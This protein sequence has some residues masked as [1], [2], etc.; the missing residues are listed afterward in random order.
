MWLSSSASKRSANSKSSSRHRPRSS[1]STTDS[2]P[3]SPTSAL[4]EVLRK[5]PFRAGSK[6]SL[7]SAR[8]EEDPS[9]ALNNDLHILADFYPDV[10]VE[11]VREL[12]LQFDG[13]SRLSICTEQLYKYKTEWAKG[14]MNVPPRGLNETIPKEE[15]FRPKEYIEAVKWTASRE[16]SVLGRST[17]DAVLAEVN[18]SYTSAR[19]T[20]Q[21]LVSRSW[22]AAFS[23]LLK[24]RRSPSEAPQVLLDKTKADPGG[25]RLV[26]TGSHELDRELSELFRTTLSPPRKTR[27]QKVTDLEYA[28]ALNLRQAEEIGALYECQ[29]CYNDTTF[30]DA[31]VCSHS[32]HVICLDCVRRALDEALFGQGWAKSVDVEHGTLKCIAPDDCDGHIPQHLVER[33]LICRDPASATETWHRFEERLAE[34]NLQRSGLPLVRCQFCP[35]AEAEQVYDPD[36]AAHIQWR[37]R[38]P[39]TVMHTIIIIL[40]LELL[41]AAVLFLMPFLLLFPTYFT[42]LFYTSLS[43]L[44]LKLRTSRFSCQNPSCLRKSCLKCQKAW[45]DPHICHEP[46]I[47]SLRTSVEAARTA[48]IKRICPRC[49]TSFVKSSGCNKLTCVC[50]YS[51]CY[52]CRKNIGKAGDN[53]EGGE[54]YRHF[55]EH[56]RPMPG[57]G[58]TECDKCDLYRAEDEDLMVKKAGEEAERLWREREG[59]VGVKGLE[60]AVGNVAGEDTWWMKLKQGS[61]T[62]QGVVDSAVSSAVIVEVD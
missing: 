16:F 37:L 61:W 28:R 30:E 52:L 19:P 44:A 11:V 48:A 49:G 56:F 18:F 31:S 58:C 33:S 20:L 21:G 50:G 24:K 4:T 12:L 26:A 53:A 5:N 54:G 27:D 43:N 34:H 57:Q 29:V 36:T 17:I 1:A 40:M 25:P 15:L 62:V 35:Y 32:G 23:N 9:I 51:M 42:T 14:R 38:K 8:E 39:T 46:L 2:R 10:K 3:T 45:H 13:D 59:M 41:P 7:S 60:D 55:C 6:E 22:K 47:V